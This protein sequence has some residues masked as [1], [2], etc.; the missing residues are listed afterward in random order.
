MATNF[1]TVREESRRYAAEVSRHLPVDKAYLFGSYAKGTADELSDVDVAFFLRDYSGK[2]RFDVGLQLLK[3][4]RSFNANF[5]PLV[6]ESAEI[7]R[8]NP[9]VNEIIN[10]GFEL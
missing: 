5:E 8:N 1:E 9:F 7:E 3:I 2:T 6:F 10:T 4:S